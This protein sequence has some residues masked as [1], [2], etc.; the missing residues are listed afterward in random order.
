MINTKANLNPKLF[1]DGV[2]FWSKK[3]RFGADLF[4]DIHADAI[5]VPSP[6]IAILANWLFGN[7]EKI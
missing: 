7:K 3:I 2:E 5:I 1:E 4:A 6:R